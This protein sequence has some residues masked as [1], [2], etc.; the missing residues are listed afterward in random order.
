MS[1]P[2]LRAVPPLDPCAGFISV[3]VLRCADGESEALGTLVDLFYALVLATVAPQRRG[4]ARAD[5]VVAVFH[6]V[7][8]RAPGF[9]SGE[10]PVAWILDVASD[11]R[12]GAS[13]PAAS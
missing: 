4:D 6:E 3:L 11:I 13:V 1:Q 2:P 8:R 5:Q 7:W 9:E 10:D 12:P